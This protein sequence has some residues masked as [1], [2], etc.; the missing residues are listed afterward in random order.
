MLK[1]SDPVKRIIDANINRF[2]EGIRVCEEVSRFIL[3]D[4]PLT[5]SLRNLRHSADAAIRR[6]PKNAIIRCRDSARDIGRKLYGG[7]LRR[8]GAAD[9]L[10]ANIQR[11]KES[12]RVLE[13]FSKLA[14]KKAAIE[15]KEARYRLYS[16]EK[17]IAEKTAGLRRFK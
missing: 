2:K 9:I 7:E 4:R 11:A 16:I 15:F 8:K 6:L 3:E 17:R 10:F 1:T 12:L 14:S 13:E 5:A